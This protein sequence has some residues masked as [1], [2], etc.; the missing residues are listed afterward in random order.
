[1][2]FVLFVDSTYGEPRAASLRQSLLVHV[3]LLIESAPT[4]PYTLVEILLNITRN[5]SENTHKQAL[6]VLIGD[7]DW[8]QNNKH[9]LVITR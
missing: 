6:Q 4:I 5:T 9:D 3:G 8:V 1:M 7:F 2:K